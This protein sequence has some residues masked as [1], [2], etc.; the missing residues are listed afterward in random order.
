MVNAI[1]I[2]FQYNSSDEHNILPGTIIDLYHAYKWCKSFCREITIFTDITTIHDWK[3]VDHA[4]E[5]NIVDMEILTFINEIPKIIVSDKIML[6][7]QISEKL[8]TEIDKLII[9]YTGHGVTNSL[10][11]PNNDHLLAIDFRN[12]ILN[13]LSPYCEI[14]WI[15]DCCSPNGLNLPFTLHN[16]IF[17]FSKFPVDC[18]TQPIILITSSF[19]SEKS[20]ASRLDS[21]FTRY[22]F[23]ILTEMSNTNKIKIHENDIYIPL[24]NNRNL[25]RLIHSIMNGI[26]HH[27]PTN[28]QQVSIYSSYQIDPVLW[29]WIGSK[30]T[31]DITLDMSLSTFVIRH[32]HPN[33]SII[34]IE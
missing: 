5:L 13:S 28:K 22:L 15:L 3:I 10:T 25:N 8:S 32:K 2:G 4:I 18:V 14:F 30:K 26:N 20:F 17:R 1:L 31:Y 23:K 16:K 33:K 11:M 6:L 19:T 9:Y 24:K 29:L 21:L 27:R 34:K 12:N 7:S